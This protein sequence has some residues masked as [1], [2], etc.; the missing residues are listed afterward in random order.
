MGTQIYYFHFEGN[1]FNVIFCDGGV[2]FSIHEQCN[3]LFKTSF[4]I[5]HT[6]LYH[7]HFQDFSEFALNAYLS[8]SGHSISKN[9]SL[10]FWVAM[11]T[12]QFA[13]SNLTKMAQ[14]EEKKSTREHISLL[15]LEKKV[16]NVIL[17]CFMTSRVNF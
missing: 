6:K 1:K 4:L 11:V 17:F 7:G 2:V 14:N 10:W 3:Q 5:E 9:N 8:T 12:K 16:S 15:L 13:I